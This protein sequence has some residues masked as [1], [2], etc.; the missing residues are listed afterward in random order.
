MICLTLVI[1]GQSLT[2]REAATTN[3]RRTIT[4]ASQIKTLVPF[5]LAHSNMVQ[6]KRVK[7]VRHPNW[8]ISFT[9]WILKKLRNYTKNKVD[10]GQSIVF[11]VTKARSGHIAHSQ[12]Q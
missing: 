11:L 7:G 3:R 1:S 6:V 2:A 4:A 9:A 12:S 8:S 10:D 5:L